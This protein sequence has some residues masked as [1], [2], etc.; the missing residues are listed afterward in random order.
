[1]TDFRPPRATPFLGVLL[2]LPFCEAV[3]SYIDPGS[4]SLVI[5]AV[6]GAVAAM[7]VAM[8]MFWKQIKAF[9][10]SVFSRFGKRE[11]SGKG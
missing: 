10:V 9:A 1:M 6:I 5:Q 4:G 3:H 2:A 7:A 11:P 8:G